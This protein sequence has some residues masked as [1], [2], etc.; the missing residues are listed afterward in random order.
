MGQED[1][2]RSAGPGLLDELLLEASPD[3]DP[4]IL[5]ALREPIDPAAR[6]GPRRWTGC[7]DPA[8]LAVENGWCWTPEHVGYVAVRRRC[9]AHTAQMPGTGG[10]TGIRARH[11]ATAPGTRGTL[12]DESSNRPAPPAAEP[13]WAPT[14]TRRGRRSRARGRADRVQAPERLRA[15]STDA[16]DDHRVADDR[17]RLPAVSLPPHARRGDDTRSPERRRGTPA[18][19]PVPGRPGLTRFPRRLGDLAGAL[20]DRP[21]VRRLAL[22][23][24]LPA[25]SR[26]IREEYSRLSANPPPALRERVRPR[27]AA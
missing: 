23:E 4:A 6:S 13:F 26:T 18:A 22:P 14:I 16:L 27:G 1:D 25:A 15:S 5:A 11:G 17:R 20:L 3:P 7:L 21:P 8:P 10:S 19:Q 12:R 2:R 24:R 9:P